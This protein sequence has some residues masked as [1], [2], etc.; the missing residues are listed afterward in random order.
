MVSYLES[1]ST[2]IDLTVLYN[3]PLPDLVE[4]EMSLS[5]PRP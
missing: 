1:A 5:H 3:S 2:N 4:I